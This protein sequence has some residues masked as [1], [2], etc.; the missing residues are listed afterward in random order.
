MNHDSTIWVVGDDID[1]VAAVTVA[2]SASGMT[3][4]HADGP[5]AF[6]DH[7]DGSA[8]TSAVLMWPLS[9]TSAAQTLQMLRKRYPQRPLHVVASNADDA[10]QA[11]ALGAATV[12]G[13][14][15]TGAMRLQ[16]LWARQTDI[17]IGG[18][19]HTTQLAPTTDAA[20][21]AVRA[22]RGKGDFQQER[23]ALCELIE[24]DPDNDLAWDRLLALDYDA[25]D[26]QTLAETLTARLPHVQ[27][28][29]EMHKLSKRLLAVCIDDLRDGEWA[30][31]VC[32]DWRERDLDNEDLQRILLD[33]LQRLGRWSELAELLADIA[34]AASFDQRAPWLVRL[35]DVQ[36]HHLA[37]YNAAALTV[38]EAIALQADPALIDRQEKLQKRHQSGSRPSLSLVRPAEPTSAQTMRRTMAAAADALRATGTVDIPPPIP[39][40]GRAAAVA[41]D[42]SAPSRAIARYLEALM[43]DHGEQIDANA[44]DLLERARDA[45]D[46]MQSRIA[47]TLGSQQR[48]TVPVDVGE[49]MRDVLADLSAELDAH[50]ATVRFEALPKVSADRDTLARILQNLVSNAVKHGSE[51][52]VIT[53]SAVAN[54]TGWEFLVH[55]DGPGLPV[56]AHLFEVAT[57]G[58]TD[59]DGHG[60]G[61]AIC[62]DLVDRL[63]GRIGARSGNG[64]GTTVH[65]TLPTTKIAA[66]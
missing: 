1:L 47:E 45:A 6:A 20:H 39:V 36:E 28:R 61:L 25:G 16:Q 9:W 33:M 7:L 27:G 23:A 5:L 60:L 13:N 24:Q 3:V 41:H 35:A 38:A 57:R 58:P 12:V 65:F 17:D 37:D 46:R 49:V 18:I 44:A 15:M 56:N 50:N 40:A 34:A 52:P 53:V 30:L 51:E 26:P 42:L 29:A 31:Q 55:D 22:A 2:A 54:D 64:D 4:L 32:L 43:E 14:T 8:W 19:G 66:G 21:D 11:A 63:G 48:S 59:A 10:G 62:R